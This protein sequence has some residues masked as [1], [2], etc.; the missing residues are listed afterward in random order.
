MFTVRD[1]F[2]FGIT[3]AI[4]LYPFLGKGKNAVELVTNQNY[5]SSKIGE[6]RF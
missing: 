6:T 1:I 2:G 3:D 4:L 5:F